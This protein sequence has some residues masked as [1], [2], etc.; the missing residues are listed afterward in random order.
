M[1]HKAGLGGSVYWYTPPELHERLEW[2]FG[3]FSLDVAASADS[4]LADKYYTKEDDGLAQDWAK[5]AG[6]RGV[7]YCNPPYDVAP[8]KWM[9]KAW[10]ESRRGVTVV[11]LV[12]ASVGANWWRAWVSGKGCVRILPGRLRYASR[13]DPTKT[14]CAGYASAIVIYRPPSVHLPPG[15]PRAYRF[16]KTEVRK[17]RKKGLSWT[18][19][20]NA[21][22]MPPN[23][24]RSVQRACA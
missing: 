19:I 7:V 13:L 1:W 15:R 16:D 6:R 10:E 23:A 11:C 9:R 21:L 8:T 17:L 5:D 24:K 14:Q 12:Q 3:R 2:E 20:L 22:G 18:A 4:H